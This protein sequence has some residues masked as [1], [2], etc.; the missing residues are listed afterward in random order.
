MG[1]NFRLTQSR[2]IMLS[3]SQWSHFFPIKSISLP[4]D[5]QDWTFSGSVNIMGSIPKD[6]NA[7]TINDDLTQDN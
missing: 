5:S 2:P 6:T 7:Y 4:A 3:P 1:D